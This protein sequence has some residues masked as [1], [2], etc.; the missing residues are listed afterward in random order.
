MSLPVKLICRANK[1]HV[2]GTCSIFIQYCCDKK[3]KPLFG[4]GI[5]IP[6]SYW[7]KKNR[8]IYT[9]L[10]PEYGN[11]KELNIEL[12]RLKKIVQDLFTYAALKKIQNRVEFVRKYYSSRCEIS[13]IEAKEKEIAEQKE[14]EKKNELSLY[15]QFDEYIKSKTRKVSKATLTVYGNVKSHVLA[16]EKFRGQEI[17]FDS[18]D[19]SFYEDFVDYLTF[20]HVHMRRKILLTGLKLN[21]IGKTIKHLRGFI[22]DRVKR[23]IITPIDLSDY[24]NTGGG[25]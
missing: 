5:K 12:A 2:D 22:K 25:K 10:P 19:F 6:A 18:F 4:T 13:D 16:F 1:V 7:N 8:C 24:K 11:C 9:Q 21:S 15:N 23:K 17:T 14:T 3:N 20:E